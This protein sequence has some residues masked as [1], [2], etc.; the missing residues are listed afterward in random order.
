MKNLMAQ[1]I[2]GAE[3]LLA[4]YRSRSVINSSPSSVA[5]RLPAYRSQLRYPTAQAI[6]R[7]VGIH[8]V[9]SN[10]CRTDAEPRKLHSCWRCE[11]RL[12][13]LCLSCSTS[14]FG[15]STAVTC[16]RAPIRWVATGCERRGTA[17]GVSGRLSRVRFGGRVARGPHTLAARSRRLLAD[18]QGLSTLD[19]GGSGRGHLLDP[20]TQTPPPEPACWGAGGV[21]HGHRPVAG[22]PHW[23]D[24]SV[25]PF[26]T[27]LIINRRFLHGRH[28][29]GS[30]GGPTS[31][32]CV[33]AVD[34]YG[35]KESNRKPT[36]AVP[37]CAPRARYRGPPRQS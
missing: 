9:T 8:Y 21:C 30:S 27:H 4:L 7:S 31:T 26:A 34:G 2:R 20:V 16:H 3:C 35:D 37:L 28:R 13:V 11:L 1:G 5:R 19:G 25:D 14:L 29:R 23:P 22:Q 36:Q 24:I 18:P 32:W 17:G 15:V 12:G 33:H 10:R 6:G